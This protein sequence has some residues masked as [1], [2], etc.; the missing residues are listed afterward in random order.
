MACA[1][2]KIERESGPSACLPHAPPPLRHDNAVNALRQTKPS[3]DVYYCYPWIWWLTR[4]ATVTQPGPRSCHPAIPPGH[5]GV[6]PLHRGASH[7]PGAQRA[8]TGAVGSESPRH[9]DEAVH[10]PPQQA[11]TLSASLTQGAER[12]PAHWVNTLDGWCTHAGF[13]AGERRDA[14]THSASRIGHGVEDVP[15]IATEARHAAA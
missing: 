2:A 12:E 10:L 1:L 8:R 4:P 7:L 3:S 13:A 6:A 11:S 9:P 5:W 15:E 14:V